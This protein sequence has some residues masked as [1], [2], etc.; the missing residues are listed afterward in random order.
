MYDQFFKGLRAQHQRRKVFT[1]PRY[2]APSRIVIWSA[3][4]MRLSPAV[5]GSVMEALWWLVHTEP[6]RSAVLSERLIGSP[7]PLRLRHPVIA[8]ISS[9]CH[10]SS[11]SLVS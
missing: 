2:L 5:N 8:A 7:S 4:L 1:L 6:Q 9:A 10:A 3:I 11:C